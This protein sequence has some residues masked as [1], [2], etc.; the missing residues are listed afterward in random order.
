MR[1]KC[2]RPTDITDVSAPSRHYAYTSRCRHSVRRSPRPHCA[3]DAAHRPSLLPLVHETCSRHIRAAVQTVPSHT[4][5]TEWGGQLSRIL[6][7][8][9]ANT[10]SSIVLINMVLINTPANNRNPTFTPSGYLPL[11]KSPSLTFHLWLG[12]KYRV[13]V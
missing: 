4:G 8:A 3:Y 5:C 12:L 11:R 13:T 2:C 1:I 6:C 9:E 7:G 10:R